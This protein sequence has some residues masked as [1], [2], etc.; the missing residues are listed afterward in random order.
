MQNDCFSDA[1]PDWEKHP[2]SSLAEIN[3]RYPLKKGH[4]Y[5]FLE[6]AAVAEQFGGIVGFAQRKMEGSGLAKFRVGDTL[7]AKITPCPENGKIAYVGTLSGEYGIGSTEFIVLSPKSGC[8]PRFLYHLM[9]CHPVRGRA[10][11]R[12]EGSTGRQRVPDDVFH[13]RLLVPIPDKDEQVAIA[14]VLDAVE[15]VVRRLSA[16]INRAL[17]LR[18]SLL[19]HLLSA[20]VGSGGSIRLFEESPTEFAPTRLGRLPFEWRISRVGDEFELQNGFTLNAERRPRY[21]KRRY[22]R[23][24]NVQRDALDLG[25]VQELEARDFEFAPRRLRE[26]DLLVVEGHADRMQIGRCARVTVEAEGMTFQ[27][28]LFRLRTLGEVLPYFGC[29]WLNSEYAQRYW[30]ARCATSSGLNTI[31]QRTLRKLPVPVP[32]KHEQDIIQRIVSSQRAHYDALVARRQMFL[33][34]HKALTSDLLAGHVRLS[35]IR[36]ESAGAA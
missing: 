23:V 18:N 12:M 32:P 21:R 17:T 5:P 9:C 4:L 19:S 16:L 15:L 13:K 1:V 33:D 36:T 11:S 10:T 14:R 22:L 7:F 28:H 8:D 3:P 30:N 6:M 29:L 20:G 24:A 25:D 26:N 35:T 27:N 2:L 31:N 34:L